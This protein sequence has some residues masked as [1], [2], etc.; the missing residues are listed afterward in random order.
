[1]TR[2]ES[3]CRRAGWKLL[4]IGAAALI[5]WLLSSFNVNAQAVSA[6]PPVAMVKQQPFP[7]SMGVAM[8][9]TTYGLVKAKL[10]AAE[11]LR[12][13]SQKTVESLQ[14]EIRQ[15]RQALD[16]QFRLG[17]YDA[18]VAMGLTAKMNLL[19]A[20][21][22]RAQET[23]RSAETAIDG[24]LQLLPRHIRKNLAVG[25]PD[26]IADALSDYVSTLKKR[27]WT[28]SGS[29]LIVGVVTGIALIL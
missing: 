9:T 4:V 25:Q 15:T 8:D 1:M 3:I 13:S 6:A 19:Q 26:K 10:R 7:F 2:Y 22:V 12:I 24:V 16:D 27:K 29:F 18:G 17:K 11:Q 14:L 21:L 23:L 5:A 28:W 20:D